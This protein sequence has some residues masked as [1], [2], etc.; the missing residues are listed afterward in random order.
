MVG[1]TV[2]HEAQPHHQP[3]HAG[4]VRVEPIEPRLVPAIE[5]RNE[6][7]AAARRG[8]AQS[9]C[10]RCRREG[11]RLLLLRLRAGARL[12]R[13][14]L[15]LVLLPRQ[16]RRLLGRAGL[17]LLHPRALGRLERLARLALALLVV[18]AHRLAQ[19]PVLDHHAAVE[20]LARER[21]ERLRVLQ[22]GL[23]RLALV[24]VAVGR[25][26]RVLELLLCDRADVLV[27]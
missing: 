12:L 5:A 8:G 15:T 1:V 22:H 4:L 14:E 6:R 18:L 10:L 2:G 26:V 21:R 17:L 7:T 25:D 24:A 27:G 9:L 20:R 16:G 19:V 13:R 11:V 23:E 3:P